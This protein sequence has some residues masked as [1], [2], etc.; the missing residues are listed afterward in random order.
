MNSLLGMFQEF[1]LQLQYS[2]VTGLLLQST[3]FVEK[4]SM[5]ASSECYLKT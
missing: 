4:L 3:F 2:Q 5:A 1:E